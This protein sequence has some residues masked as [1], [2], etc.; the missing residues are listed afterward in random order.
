MS[1]NQVTKDAISS[2]LENLLLTKPFAKITVKDITDTCGISRNT[3]YYHFKDKYELMHWIL[4]EDLAR[5]I[6]NYDDPRKIADTFIAIC[7]FMFKRRNLYYSFLQYR[8]QNSLQ[9]YLTSFYFE[10]WRLNTDM[11]YENSGLKLSDN[12]IEVYA[13]MNAHA[14]VGLMNDWVNNGMHDNYMRYFDQVDA[15][16]HLQSEL[17]AI[18]SEH[19]MTAEMTQQPTNTINR[20]EVS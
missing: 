18:M 3:F 6:K 5:N 11:Q 4:N 13:R 12:E 17:Y 7:Q 9:E 2:T 19:R 1:A 15:I 10:L 20:V 16:L 8:G 14:L